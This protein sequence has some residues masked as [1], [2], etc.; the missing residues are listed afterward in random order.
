MDNKQR[1]ALVVYVEGAVQTTG[2]GPRAIL[3]GMVSDVLTLARPPANALSRVRFRIGNHDLC[4]PDYKQVLMWAKALTLEPVE[5]VLRLAKGSDGK[6]IG[7]PILKVDNGSIVTLTWNFELLPLSIFEWTPGLLIQEI[8]F[9]GP[10]TAPKLSLRLP[11]LTQLV[12]MKIGLTELDLSKVPNLSWL[13]CSDNQLTELDLSQ[14]PNLSF[15]GC[16]YNQLTELDLSQVRNLTEFDC[17]YNQLAEIDLSQIPDLTE[18]AC[19][20][21]QLTE[22]DLSQ[23]PDLTELLCFGNQ[24]TELDLSQVPNLTVLLCYR[25]QLT[26][27]DL[28][29]VPL[30]SKLWCG[31][32]QLTELDIRHLMN[33]KEVTCDPSVN[34]KKRPDQVR[35]NE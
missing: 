23:V 32:N 31:R 2:Q 5:V 22:L 14:V 30:L 8:S 18:L 26:E 10:I 16:S 9:K 1:N 27:L 3:S 17:Y 11:L 29:K 33:L 25:N 15:L 34:L 7:E 4:A 20:G 35:K 21:N 24:L 12:C 6:W 13:A 19:F 28:S